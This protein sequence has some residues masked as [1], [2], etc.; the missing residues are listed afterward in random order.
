MSSLPDHLPERLRLLGLRDVSRILTHTNR[1]VM[2]S[3]GSDGTLRLHRGYDDADLVTVAPEASTAI[4]AS[5]PS[6]FPP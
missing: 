5:P 4:V 1:T 6:V 3:I 2:V